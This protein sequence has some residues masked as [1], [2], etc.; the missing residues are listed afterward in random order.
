MRGTF[1]WLTSELTTLAKVKYKKQTLSLPP[2][3][4]GLFYDLI[5]L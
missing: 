1:E 3:L 5:R 2:I 4:A